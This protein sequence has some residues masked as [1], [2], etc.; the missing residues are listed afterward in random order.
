MPRNHSKKQSLCLGM[1]HWINCVSNGHD[2]N[3]PLLTSM[4][5]CKLGDNIMINWY[6]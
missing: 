5:N 3:G 6:L 1:C 2:P 4:N